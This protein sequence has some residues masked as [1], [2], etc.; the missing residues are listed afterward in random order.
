MPNL[1][2]GGADLGRVPAAG[3]GSEEGDAADAEGDGPRPE[4]GDPRGG[5]REDAAHLRAFHPRRLRYRRDGTAKGFAIPGKGPWASNDVPNSPT[6]G[7]AGP[8]KDLSLH[9]LSGPCPILSPG[10]GPQWRLGL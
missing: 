4:A 6:L 10:P 9:G 1:P 8:Q 5:Q 2:A 7:S 3:G